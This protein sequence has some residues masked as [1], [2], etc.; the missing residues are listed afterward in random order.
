[1]DWAALEQVFPAVP[2]NSVRQRVVRLR[3]I[4]GAEPYL[5]RLE[6]AW[7]DLWS[8]HRGTENLPDNDP[9]SPSNF[10]LLKHIEFLRKH[11]DK[12]A[13]YVIIAIFF[14]TFANRHDRR[15]GFA[16]Q[17]SSIKLPASIDDIARDWETVEKSNAGPVWDFLWNAQ[18]EEGREKYLLRQPFTTNASD[19]PTTTDVSSESVHLAESVVKVSIDFVPMRFRFINIT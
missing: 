16:V 15:V 5:K 7:Y 3:E 9:R 12:N 1:M 19:L 17:V 11:I 4:P 10:D 8:Q 2:K 18:V 6:D 13:M 14:D